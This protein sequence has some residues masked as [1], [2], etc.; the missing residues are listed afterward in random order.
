MNVNVLNEDHHF[1]IGIDRFPKAK[2]EIVAVLAQLDV[3]HECLNLLLD[4]VALLY[5]FVLQVGHELL[6]S[7]K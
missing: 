7:C 1:S 3:H 5:R 6:A 2:S 4:L